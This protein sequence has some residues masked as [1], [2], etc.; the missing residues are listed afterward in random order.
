MISNH[1]LLIRPRKR[2]FLGLRSIAAFLVAVFCLQDIAFANPEAKPI[3][4][5]L[6]KEVSR[7]WAKQVLPAIPASVATLE[8][9]YR[10]GDKIVYLI[11]DAHTNSSGQFNVA[12]ILE[13][14]VS[15]VEGG[16]SKVEG[17]PFYVFLEAGAGDESLSFLRKYATSKKRVEV[18]RSFVI[19]GKLQG[20][21]F[22]DL[23]SDKSFAL[24]GVEDMDLYAQSVEAY[25]AVAKNREKFQEYL[26]RVEAA[27]RVLKPRVLN[28]F[29]LSFDE[30]REKFKKGQISLT[31]YFEILTEQAVPLRDYPHLAMLNRL[32]QLESKIDFKK[33]GEEQLAAV[34]ALPAEDRKELE[35]IAG[36]MQRAAGRVD[37][38]DNRE[39]SAF[40]A[41][42][43]EKLTTV[44]A[45]SPKGDEVLRQAQDGER[46]RTAI[47]A[48]DGLLRPFGPR[49]DKYSNLFLYF[50][51]LKLSKKLDLPKILTEQKSL[52]NAVYEKLFMNTDEKSLIQASKNLEILKKLLDLT[53][54]P[55]EYDEY[56]KNKSSFDI[57][58]MTGFLNQQIMNLKAYYENAVFL[59]SGYEK[60]VKQAEEF[61]ELTYTRDQKFVENMLAKMDERMPA[62]K[63][64]AGSS[65]GEEK[66]VLITGGYHSPNLKSLLK[67]KGISYIY[68]QPQVLQETNQ[69][70]YEEILLNQ[71]MVGE[72]RR[73]APTVNVSPM[74]HTNMPM[75][76]G[77]HPEWQADIAHA[78]ADASQATQILQEFSGA[79]LATLAMPAEFYRDTRIW[80][81]FMRRISPLNSFLG[82]RLN[83]IFSASMMTSAYGGWI[84]TWMMLNTLGE[85][86]EMLVKSLSMVINTRP[87]FLARLAVSMSEI[88][89]LVR[90]A[91]WPSDFKNPISLVGT[92]SSMR[93]FIKEFKRIFRSTHTLDSSRTLPRSEARPGYGPVLIEDNNLLPGFSQGLNPPREARE[94]YTQGFGFPENEV[95]HGRFS[96]QQRYIFAANDP[97]P[98]DNT[99]L[100]ERQPKTNTGRRPAAAFMAGARLAMSEETRKRRLEEKQILDG[101]R[102]EKGAAITK[103]EL[104]R[105]LTEIPGHENAGLQTVL[106]DARRDPYLKGH[107]KLI[108][109]AKNTSADRAAAVARREAEL[110]ILGE[111]PSPIGLSRLHEL[112]KRRPGFENV[113]YQDVQNDYYNY[114]DVRIREYKNLVMDTRGLIFGILEGQSS[115]LTLRK[116]MG[117]L[118]KIPGYRTVNER[119][120][121]EYFRKDYRLLSHRNYRSSVEDW[122]WYAQTLSTKLD[123]LYE[124]KSFKITRIDHDLP[125]VEIKRGKSQFKITGASVLKITQRRPSEKM[126]LGPF[127]VRPQVP[128][129][130]E[131]KPLSAVGEMPAQR[132]AQPTWKQQRAYVSSLDPSREVRYPGPS[133]ETY[134]ILS[135]DA[136]TPSLRLFHK[137]NGKEE[138]LGQ[139]EVLKVWQG[140]MPQELSPEEPPAAETPTEATIFKMMEQINAFLVAGEVEKAK[141]VFLVLE[142]NF[143][144]LP[145]NNSL[146]EYA[147]WIDEA[148][149]L[150]SEAEEA[151]AA[152]SMSQIGEWVEEV[153]NRIRNRE[154]TQA[155]ELLGEAHRAFE[156]YPESERDEWVRGRLSRA[157]QWLALPL[158]RVAIRAKNLPE[159]KEHLA[160]ARALLADA[161]HDR[162]FLT[163]YTWYLIEEDS[164][165]ERALNAA[166]Y[167]FSLF[168]DERQAVTNLNRAKRAM[169]IYDD[170]NWTQKIDLFP[171][172][173]VLGPR[174]HGARL[175]VRRASPQAT[176]AHGVAVVPSP[177]TSLRAG[178]PSQMARRGAWLA[179]SEAKGERGKVEGKSENL[180]EPLAVVDH[181]LEVLEE[182]QTQEAGNLNNFRDVVTE[183]GNVRGVN[184]LNGNLVKSDHGSVNLAI[185]GDD[186]KAR[187]P[188]GE[189]VAQGNRR[190]ASDH[191]VGGASVQN[192]V[193][194][195][196]GFGAHQLH[197]GNDNSAGGFVERYFQSLK[198]ITAY[199]LGKKA[200]ANVMYTPVFL[201]GADSSFLWRVWRFLAWDNTV[202]S[203][204]FLSVNLKAIQSPWNFFLA[205]SSF[206]INTSNAPKY[207]TPTTQLP[208]AARGAR[209]AQSLEFEEF[210]ERVEGLAQDILAYQDKDKSDMQEFLKE[211]NGVWKSF[212]DSV[213][214]SWPKL[215]HWIVD[216]IGNSVY[217]LRLAVELR[218]EEKIRQAVN[219]LFENTHALKL[220]VDSRQLQNIGKFRKSSEGFDVSFL[221]KIKTE[222]PELY[223]R[224]QKASDVWRR[225]LP[226]TLSFKNDKERKAATPP[227]FRSVMS[228]FEKWLAGDTLTPKDLG[229]LFLG[230]KSS[231][232][233]QIGRWK[234][235]ED[236]AEEKNTGPQLWEALEFYRSP[237]GAAH[238]LRSPPVRERV[239]HADIA[240]LRSG[241]FYDTKKQRERFVDS[242]RDF[243]EQTKNFRQEL[244]DAR[245]D[246]GLE[247]EQVE[248]AAGLTAG[249]L[250]SIELGETPVD[251]PRFNKIKRIIES[252]RKKKRMAGRPEETEASAGVRTQKPRRSQEMVEE[253]AK[254]LSKKTGSWVE[255]AGRLYRLVSVSPRMWRVGD[256]DVRLMTAVLQEENVLAPIA[257]A[258]PSLM[259]IRLSRKSATASEENEGAAGAPARPEG[260]RLAIKRSKVEGGRWKED[261]ETKEGGAYAIPVRESEGLAEVHGVGERDLQAVAR[262]PQGRAIWPYQSTTPSIRF[263]TRQHRRRQG[264]LSQEGNNPIS[265][266]GARF[267]L[268][269]L[270]LDPLNGRFRVSHPETIQSIARLLRRNHSHVERPDSVSSLNT[271]FNL[272]PSTFNLSPVAAGNTGARLAEQEW[273][274]MNPENAR[275]GKVDSEAA[276]FAAEVSREQKKAGSMA[277]GETVFVV[278]YDRSTEVVAIY[279]YGQKIY[280]EEPRQVRVFERSKEASGFSAVDLKRGLEISYRKLDVFLEDA[281]FPDSRLMIQEIDLNA[282][283]KDRL[284]F[285]QVIMPLLAYEIMLAKGK[286]YGQSSQF[287]LRGDP[288]LVQ[289]IKKRAIQMGGGADFNILTDEKEIDADWKDAE[290]ILITAPGSLNEPG[291]RRLL[292]REVSTGDIPD[293]RSWFKASYLLAVPKK[294]E[295]A[296]ADFE[297]F[298]KALAV[299][300]GHEIQ[301]PKELAQAVNGQIS[302]IFILQKYAI[303]AVARLAIN[304]IVQGARLATKMAEQAA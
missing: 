199:S 61:Y 142:K 270:N 110:E 63:A 217:A 239:S 22:L 117:L 79:R 56:R 70:R 87:S 148:R 165:K 166:E 266:H 104:R 119:I 20:T 256:Q 149:R 287:L 254:K 184:V 156:S 25:R 115:A 225:L 216:V 177:S 28:P 268:R 279:A 250:E 232:I 147:D 66:A 140:V 293:F 93:N 51:Y 64:S 100:P 288:K 158:A 207:S 126:G 240:M 251:R 23:T 116:L 127:A 185:R 265:L 215:R 39:Q 294:I 73:V 4:W 33:A 227:V 55:E 54:V 21:E 276:Q 139:A 181:G 233:G 125:A 191:R 102:E 90:T 298:V 68:L 1:S 132:S 80:P 196:G 210:E 92:S 167:T 228:V 301:D 253:Y 255:Y 101:I 271:S 206:I 133:G 113:K 105:K 261:Q 241:Y 175:A 278:T 269:T 76:L 245:V 72:T 86:I 155:Q 13:T 190:V 220:I 277:V 24:W 40:Y 168:P 3:D 71:G 170:E 151:A 129:P 192:Q 263:S 173:E 50:R 52:E 284:Y 95:S 299:L 18:G 141:E 285:E 164:D 62:T 200:P 112:L 161:E 134:H 30:K 121:S 138:F 42:L 247:P 219:Q 59:E 282:L 131:A 49:N 248:Q 246:A 176:R 65:F 57:T 81:L 154:Y 128:A 136:T 230:G 47:S 297:K 88:D 82:S 169:E 9:A 243:M 226:V 43:E 36:S 135:V 160:V 229:D 224:L 137:R 5:N 46:S 283:A 83:S 187:A 53:L 58:Q 159:A 260:A 19:N 183:N 264:P 144:E 223:A 291:K 236:F 85:Y 2:K 171:V 244:V 290:R 182:A 249:E 237:E 193:D 44:I 60:I 111:Q 274:E 153:F 234:E 289:M 78:L 74:A 213:G 295:V 118:K 98:K 97:Y 26:T 281:E 201:A 16:R 27:V 31:E 231:F 189:I 75:R 205:V 94:Q 186:R 188:T 211:I 280:E 34:M 96:G 10:A 238:V 152:P 108:K 208:A 48:T 302:D 209:L 204:D 267:Y 259:D 15:K 8:D 180:Q 202:P 124:E 179:V 17:K 214:D 286:P 45:R 7:Q 194:F 6:S 222:R 35:E 195:Q 197:T 163:A 14:I 122:R 172:D 178:K 150:F 296:D 38:K 103:A 292:V 275:R 67:A 123:V 77:A 114:K 174:G 218:D 145:E 91:S 252:L 257:V 304:Q 41:L 106:D 262:F 300:T 162:Y 272:R 11:Q 273:R 212:E 37:A 109:Q 146:P 12:K 235:W 107:E 221:E 32:R 89:G 130:E 120:V 203:S 303:P 258:G 143:E 29:L 157:T 69:R 242:Y 84:W 198:R 99:R